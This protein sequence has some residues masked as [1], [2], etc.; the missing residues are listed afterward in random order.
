[1]TAAVAAMSTYLGG[2][3]TTSSIPH[4]PSI[5]HTSL[6]TTHTPSIALYCSIPL[7]I[8]LPLYTTPPLSLYT[9][10]PLYHT[11]LYT[12]PLYTTPL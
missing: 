6:Y 4:T 12:T 5:L 7:S 1:M 10:P 2:L 11:P 8:P 3:L 9:T